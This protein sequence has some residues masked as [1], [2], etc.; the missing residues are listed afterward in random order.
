MHVA[1][2]ILPS[3]ERS[4]SSDPISNLTVHLIFFN[5]L[6]RPV[7]AMTWAINLGRA[8]QNDNSISYNIFHKER[9]KQ[10]C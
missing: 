10:L 1:H 6:K 4:Y 9:Q 3:R 7:D 2:N 8:C 5:S